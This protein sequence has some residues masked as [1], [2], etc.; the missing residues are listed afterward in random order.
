M[1]QNTCQP[2]MPSRYTIL[3]CV[4]RITGGD[5]LRLSQWVFYYYLVFMSPWNY[6]NPL[7]NPM[8][9]HRDHQDVAQNETLT[10]AL[11]AGTMNSFWNDF[12]HEKFSEEGDGV[13]LA[14]VTLH[15]SISGT[16]VYMYF[17]C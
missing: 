1:Q 4:L 7:S 9:H 6:T 3:N 17:T 8:L 13:I 10:D 12:L 2:W 16:T 5:F 14:L 11:G 15:Q